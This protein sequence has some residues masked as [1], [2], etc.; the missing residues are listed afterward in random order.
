MNNRLN[1]IRSILLVFGLLTSGSGCHVLNIPSYRADAPLGL[2]GEY[3]A[4]YELGGGETGVPTDLSGAAS[5]PPEVACPPGFFPHLRG[6]PHVGFPVPSWWAEWK[7]KKDLPKP[8]P[9]PRFQPLP[10]R[11]VFQPRPVS[12]DQPW[13]EGVMA[14]TPYGQLPAPEAGAV[15]WG[16]RG[17]GAAQVPPN[18]LPPNGTRSPS[19]APVLGPE[20][21]P[22]PAELPQRRLPN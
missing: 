7:A 9:Y 17:A 22:V 12:V 15:P 1:T 4:N 18:G 6:W 11:P 13:G 5:Y 21:L 16:S 14:P 8:P 10:T 3:P 2:C 19:L 20:P